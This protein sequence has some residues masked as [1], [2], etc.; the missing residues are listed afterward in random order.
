VLKKLLISAA[1]AGVTVAVPAAAFADSC[2]NVSRGARPVWHDVQRSCHPGQL[3]VAA[4]Y[5]CAR[6]GMGIRAAWSRRLRVVRFPGC[7]RQLH[8]RPDQLSARYERHLQRRG[9]CSPDGTWHS[10]RLR[11]DSR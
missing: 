1:L 6:P 3:G 11:I 5:W 2:S 4:E 8:Q 10:N 7:Q 9:G